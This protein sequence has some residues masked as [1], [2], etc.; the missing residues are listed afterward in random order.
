MAHPNYD[1]F[2]KAHNLLPHLRNVRAAMLVVGGWYDT[3]DLYGPLHIYA[4]LQAQNPGIKNSLVLGPWVHGGWS[5]TDGSGLGDADF[6]TRTSEA[7]A[8]L[9]LAFFL[10]HLK[11][12]PA[13]SWTGC[14]PCSAAAPGW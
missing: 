8:A 2:W 4:A 5:R 7:H 11:G 1:D 10:H 14:L 9:E 12:G 3:E 6:G 13:P